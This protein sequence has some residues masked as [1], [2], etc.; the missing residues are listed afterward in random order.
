MLPGLSVELAASRSDRKR[1]LELHREVY[2]RKGLLRE[3]T[4]RPQVLPQACVPGSAIFVARENG[5]VV[6]TISFY[7]DSVLGLPMDDVHGEEV[8]VMRGRFTR[9]AEV[10]GLAVLED[11]RGVGIT[12]LLYLATYRWALATGAQC[13]V[14]CVNPSSRRA[15]SRMFLFEVLGECKRHPRY[16]GAPSIPIGFVLTTALRRYLKTRNGK[17]D[18]SSDEFFC[19]PHMYADLGAA[20]YLQWSNDEVSEMI[21]TEQLTL[22]GDDRLYVERHYSTNGMAHSPA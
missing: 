13:I 18:D 12:M 20:Q 17:P 6:G 9:I 15:Y 5:E 19:D 1:A 8:D 10:G 11:R 22:V 2:R 3:S 16:Q 4:L 7:M 21:K 14:A